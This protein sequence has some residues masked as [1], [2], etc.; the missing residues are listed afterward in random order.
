MNPLKGVRGFAAQLLQRSMEVTSG[1]ILSLYMGSFSLAKISRLVSRLVSQLVEAVVVFRKKQMADSI[2]NFDS[3]IFHRE[4]SL[5]S[6]T[7]V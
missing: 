1:R 6:P 4:F 7:H 2:E 3:I 5:V